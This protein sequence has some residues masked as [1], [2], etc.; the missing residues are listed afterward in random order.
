MRIKR[1]HFNILILVVAAIGGAALGYFHYALVDTERIEFSSAF[2]TGYIVATMGTLA[3]T[4]WQLLAIAYRGLRWGGLLSHTMTLLVMLV[5]W[6]SSIGGA[7]IYHEFFRA[8]DMAVRLQLSV[9][10]ALPLFLLVAF[11]D[12]FA[13]IV[14]PMLIT[15]AALMFSRK[16]D[17]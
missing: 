2:L 14:L 13:L 17:A 9:L 6:L 11:V 3:F 15:R 8:E 12:T 16:R 1:S 7:A 4:I 10:Q 5:F